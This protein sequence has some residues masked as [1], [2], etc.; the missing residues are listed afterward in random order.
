M[1]CEFKKIKNFISCDNYT[2]F[3]LHEDF[4]TSTDV[5]IS[6]SGNYQDVGDTT[7]EDCFD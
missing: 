5:N 6:S 2:L 7:S 4:N 1:F 3:T